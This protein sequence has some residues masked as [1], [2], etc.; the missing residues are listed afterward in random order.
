VYHRAFDRKRYLN[1][2]GAFDP[3]ADQEFAELL[4]HADTER[5][6]LSAMDSARLVQQSMA[7]L[8]ALQR[9]TIEMAFVEG[10]TMHE[11][12]ERTGESFASVR[13]HY[14]RGLE[15]MRTILGTHSKNGRG[16]LAGGQAAYVQS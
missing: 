10:L 13:H 4:P 2:R 11:I 16:H 12:A 1:R 5:D 15:K 9:K 3:V 14:Y 8:S 7:H 6:A